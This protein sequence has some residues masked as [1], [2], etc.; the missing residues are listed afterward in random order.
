MAGQEHFGSRLGAAVGAVA[1]QGPGLRPAERD[2]GHIVGFHD[3]W[4]GEFGYERLP[5]THLGDT[6]YVVI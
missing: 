1:L 6:T 4:A 5:I 3:H 2:R